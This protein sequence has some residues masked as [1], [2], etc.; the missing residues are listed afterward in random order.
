MD[1]FDGGPYYGGEI[2]NLAPV[3]SFATYRAIKGESAEREGIRYLISRED[4]RGFRAVAAAAAVDNRRMI[5]P[6]LILDILRTK[7]G[8]RIDAVPLP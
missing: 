1:P 2:E 7:D 3:R 8:D 5:I 6:G 4:A